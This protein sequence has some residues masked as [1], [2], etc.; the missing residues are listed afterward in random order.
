MKA[1]AGTYAIHESAVSSSVFK[2]SL[3]VM[4]ECNLVISKVFLK[5]KPKLSELT[6]THTY[7]H[8]YFTSCDVQNLSPASVPLTVGKGKNPSPS[9]WVCISLSKR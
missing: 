8:S 2:Y 9:P 4:I 5:L 7:T 1:F 6:H 3:H